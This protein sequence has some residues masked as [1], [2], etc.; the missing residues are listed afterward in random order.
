ML[1]RVFCNGLESTQTFRPKQFFPPAALFLEG[2]GVENSGKTGLLPFLNFECRSYLLRSTSWQRAILTLYLRPE[3]GSWC[4][5]LRSEYFKVGQKE[6]ALA[7]LQCRNF[8]WLLGTENVI[9]S[10]GHGSL[11]K[12]EAGDSGIVSSASVWPCSDRIRILGFEGISVSLR[13]GC[14]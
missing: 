14:V 11:A 1:V 9:W 5:T 7:L 13:L 6:L 8:H 4:R 3:T 10:Q 2:S 12:P